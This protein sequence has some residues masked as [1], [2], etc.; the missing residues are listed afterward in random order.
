MEEVPR[1]EDDGWRVG[2]EAHADRVVTRRE[3]VELLAQD[4]PHEG[5]AP[6]ARHQVLFRMERDRALADLGLVVARE[7]AMLLLGQL[8][9]ELAVETGAHAPELAGRPH[10]PRGVDAEARV[11]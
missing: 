9:P 7:A 6:I 1:L 10:A 4:A 8:L 2:V 3:G 11:V 5:H